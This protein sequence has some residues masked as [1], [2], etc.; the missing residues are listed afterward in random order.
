[1]KVGCRHLKSTRLATEGSAGFDLSVEDSLWRTG[2]GIMRYVSTARMQPDAWPQA[3][4]PED[5]VDGAIFFLAPFPDCDFS[6]EFTPVGGGG[7]AERGMIQTPS[8]RALGE[9]VQITEWVAIGTGGDEAHTG[10]GPFAFC[11]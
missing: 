8:P 11:T 5:G 10:R 3:Q 1:M 7:G 2:T 6:L 9:R 4:P